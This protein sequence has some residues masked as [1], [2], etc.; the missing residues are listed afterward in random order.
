M[1][2]RRLLATT[3]S[4]GL[5]AALA[6][7]ATP[8]SIPVGTQLTQALTIA[9][10][11]DAALIKITTDIATPPIS[12]I[13]PGTEQT[14]I[15]GLQTAETGISAFLN[16]TTPPAGASTLDQINAYLTIALNTAAPVLASVL[17]Q[18][19]PIILALEAIDALLPV[20]EAMLTPPAA[21]TAAAALGRVQVHQ[22]AMA[23]VTMSQAQALAT[24]KTYLGGK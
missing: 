7:C 23:H 5:L 6:A 3:G 2:R 22:H 12:L 16:Q 4:F 1:N 13:T 14:V 10:T 18:A 8:T 19:Q 17:P 20:W 24:L 15:A 11:V 9:Q 21:A